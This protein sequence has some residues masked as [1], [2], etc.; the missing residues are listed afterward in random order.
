[1]AHSAQHVPE[2]APEEPSWVRPEPLRRNLETERIEKICDA[3]VLVLLVGV[4]VLTPIAFG[5]A[6]QDL[7]PFSK[8]PFGTVL[9]YFN[10]I[11]VAA[12]VLMVLAWAVKMMLTERIVLAR[13]PLDLPLLLFLAYAFVRALTCAAPTVALREVGWITAY[14]AIFYVAVNVLRTRRQ[15]HIAVGAIVGAALLL[16]L[17]ALALTLQPKARDFALTLERPS[18]YHGRLGASYICPNHFAGYLE[19]AIPLVLAFIMISKARLAHKIV[20]GALGLAMVI[21][22]IFSMSRGGWI[23]LT[24]GITFLLAAA[25]TQKRINLLA[26]ILPLI[27]IVVTVTAIIARDPRVRQRFAVV[28]DKEDL[29]YGGRALAWK[30]TLDV[31]QRRPVFGTGPGTYRWA[32]TRAQ[33]QGLRL[34]VRYTHNDYLHTLSDYGAVGLGLVLWAAGAF[35]YR[36]VR[37]LRRAKK[38]SDLALAIGVM[39]S[40]VAIAAHS[41]VDF[42]MRIPANLVTMLV[43]AAVLVAV[44]QYQLRRLAELVIFKRR[45]EVRLRTATKVAAIAAVSLASVA[46]LIVNARKHEARIAYHRGRESDTTLVEPIGLKERV[47]NEVSQIESVTPKQLDAVVKAIAQLESPTAR[48]IDQTIRQVARAKQLEP[49][50]VDALITAASRA[51]RLTLEDQDLIVTAYQKAIRLDHSNFEFHAALLNFYRWKGANSVLRK[52]VALEAFGRAIPYGKDAFRL[53]PLSARV[54][55]NMGETYKWT[56]SILKAD[57][58]FGLVDKSAYKPLDFYEAQARRW[59]DTAIRLHPENGIYREGYGQFFEWAGELRSALVQYNKGL[60]IFAD[61][62][63]HQAVFK[64]RIRR[65]EK[66]LRQLEPG[67]STPDEAAPGDESN[68]AT[69]DNATEP[70]SK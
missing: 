58:P 36:G 52:D 45:G 33:P 43:L 68:E 17:V 9:Y 4:L 54:A 46:I 38:S 7:A 60:K 63:W 55:F 5:G 25:T 51:R 35:A 26:W 57:D 42:N 67:P 70:E 56:Y 47:V 61:A 16:T 20:A 2:T 50:Q 65:I 12:A 40:A 41:F 29:S 39:A 23:S 6:D 49:R 32:F 53:N 21:A 3:I 62:P 59:Y 1:M 8:T 44:R 22:I 66:K 11:I 64:K 13:T 19:M 48:E 15:Q 69:G 37:A 24:L 28:A 10:Y 14:V 18:G 27:A 34:D 30:H 31:V